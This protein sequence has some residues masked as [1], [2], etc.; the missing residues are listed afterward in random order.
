[1]SAQW[2][3]LYIGDYIRDT[4]RLTTLEHGAYML[5]IMEYWTNHG[6]PDDDR[7]LARIAGL[8][9]EEWSQVRPAIAEL[10]Q[11]GWKHKRIDKEL[12]RAT[13]KSDA[14]RAAAEL[15]WQRERE[16]EAMRTHSVGNANAMLPE[17]Q[18][19]P[20]ELNTKIQETSRDGLVASQTAP[21]KAKRAKARSQIDENAQPDEKDRVS[22]AEH[23]LSAELFRSEWRKFRDHHLAKGSLFAD[24]N[25]AWRKWC[26]NVAQFQPPNARAGPRD[27][28]TFK[29]G[30]AA[31]HEGIINGKFGEDDGGECP[32]AAPAG[33]AGLVRS[34]AFDAREVGGGPLLDLVST[35][36]DD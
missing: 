22:A 8:S 31:V 6:L 16:A 7:R 3:P 36:S 19:Q 18:P 34:P 12:A 4:R 13:G 11:D 35:R 27:G 15:R 25:A 26:G 29:N 1:M 32:F 10:F 5:L 20:E 14:A 23:G 2:M 17:P 28:P 30:F 21:R 33:Q 9:I 24:W